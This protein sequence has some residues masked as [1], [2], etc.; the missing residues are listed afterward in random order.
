MGV[1]TAN[2]LEIVLSRNAK[3]EKL[4]LAK[5]HGPA[6]EEAMVGI[7]TQSSSLVHLDLSYSALGPASGLLVALRANTA[8]RHL[9]LNCCGLNN[10]HARKLCTIGLPPAL[11]TL[12]MRD[13]TIGEG[14]KGC[15]AMQLESIVRDRRAAA[16]ELGLDPTQSRA[17]RE[18]EEELGAGA[19]MPVSDVVMELAASIL[20]APHMERFNE[21]SLTALRAVARENHVA[22]TGGT[23][24]LLN[25]CVLIGAVQDP[26]GIASSGSP[27]FL[28]LKLS[29]NHLSSQEALMVLE[30]VG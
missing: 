16:A 15:T 12:D 27:C 11:R 17:L 10:E 20:C 14:A 29:S 28:L 6:M 8:L 5:P 2:V 24:P 23:Q 18:R 9:Y 21:M 1:L 13:N 25:A 22:N 19:P 30:K 4:R 26:S 7:L 3:L